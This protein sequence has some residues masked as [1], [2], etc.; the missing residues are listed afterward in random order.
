[1]NRVSDAIPLG[2][3]DGT[4]KNCLRPIGIAI[5]KGGLW[6]CDNCRKALVRDGKVPS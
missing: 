1:M 6:C 5:F 4:C 3:A 2:E